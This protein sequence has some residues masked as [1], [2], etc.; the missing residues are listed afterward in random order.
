MEE[1]THEQT[2]DD[3]PRE[4]TTPLRGAMR[5][6]WCEVGPEDPHFTPFACLCVFS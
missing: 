4:E 3:D 6:D 1:A 2:V 5:G